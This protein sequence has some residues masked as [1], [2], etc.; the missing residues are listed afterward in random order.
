MLLVLTLLFAGEAPAPDAPQVWN[1]VKARYALAETYRDEVTAGPLHF[2]TVFSRTDGIRMEG[3]ERRSGI[4][5]VTFGKPPCIRLYDL[6][7]SNLHDCSASR[8]L[9]AIGYVQEPQTVIPALLMPELKVIPVDHPASTS[10]SLD[11]LVI[12]EFRNSYRDV[13]RY[14]VDP[15]SYT[16]RRFEHA[17][18]AYDDPSKVVPGELIEFENV[19]FTSPVSRSDVTFRLPPYGAARNHPGVTALLLW[20]LIGAA[21]YLLTLRT[22]RHDGLS[23]SWRQERRNS[24]LRFAKCAGILITLLALLFGITLLV[25]G[26]HPP[27]AI[28]PMILAYPVFFVLVTLGAWLA[29]RDLAIQI[30]ASK[31]QRV[32]SASG[33]D[34]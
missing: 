28:I 8:P 6:I 1:S 27:A 11:G 2:R 33:P 7:A 13:Y 31:H 3:S 20:F 30:R 12:L 25:P 29:G 24:W 17:R 34:Q 32:A 15:S 22:L 26:G 18:I 14:F 16:V 9:P 19:S 21:H 10:T 4:S 5:W 23:P